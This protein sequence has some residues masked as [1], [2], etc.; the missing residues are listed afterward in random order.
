MIIFAFYLLPAL[1][2]EEDNEITTIHLFTKFQNE[3]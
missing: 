3:A 2:S 1:S